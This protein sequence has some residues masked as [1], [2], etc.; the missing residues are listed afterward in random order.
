MTRILGMV[1]SVVIV[2][3]STTGGFSFQPIGPYPNAFDTEPRGI[4]LSQTIVGFYQPMGGFDHGHLQAG[5]S[6]KT[7]EPSGSLSSYLEGI[8]DKGTAV[9][10]YCDTLSCNPAQAQEHLK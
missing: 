2:S 1:L 3:A 5:K 7:I 6:Y 4:N 10:G 8:N 9:G